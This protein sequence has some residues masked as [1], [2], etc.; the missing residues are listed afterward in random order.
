MGVVSF[1]DFSSVLSP[2]SRSQ[3]VIVVIVNQILQ[4]TMNL[5]VPVIAND[6]VFCFETRGRNTW[7]VVPYD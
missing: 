6:G 2:T 5:D 7:F 1:L 3:E 4:E